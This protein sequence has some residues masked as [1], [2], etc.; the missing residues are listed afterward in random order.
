MSNIDKVKDD[1]EKDYLH[2]QGKPSVAPQTSEEEQNLAKANASTELVEAI[3]E[4][5]ES[6]CAK[7]VADDG[8]AKSK[9]T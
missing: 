2:P 7:K 3:S 9:A 4:D 5:S 8:Q 6:A 1:T